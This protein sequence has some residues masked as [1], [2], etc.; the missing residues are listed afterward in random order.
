MA[1]YS[2]KQLSMILSAHA[3]GQ[4]KR[5]GSNNLG[6][7]GRGCVNQIAFNEPSCAVALGGTSSARRA[8]AIWFD[9]CYDKAMKPEVLLR[10]LESF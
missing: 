9:R 2:E 1:L 6:S 4:L 10:K 8:A 5:F 3:A 7:W